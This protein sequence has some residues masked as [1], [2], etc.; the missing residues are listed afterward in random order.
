M[1]HLITL[2][3]VT[4][5]AAGCSNDSGG[6]DE[7]VRDDVAKIAISEGGHITLNG[8]DAGMDDV[9]E[10]LAQLERHDGVVWYYR[11]AAGAEPH[12]NAM[13]VIDAIAEAGL[14]ISMSTKPNFSDEV[15]PDGSTRPRRD[16]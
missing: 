4:V 1:R 12:P 7:T 2:A 3:L 10:A 15:G 6:P 8:R 16:R 14:P 5:L 13:R 11:E 9:R